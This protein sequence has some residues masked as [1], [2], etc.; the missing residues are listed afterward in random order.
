VVT[1]SVRDSIVM[2]GCSLVVLSELEADDADVADAPV[3]AFI[4]STSANGCAPTVAM[5]SRRWGHYQ[6]IEESVS[7][8]KW[9]SCSAGNNTKASV[10]RTGQLGAPLCDEAGIGGGGECAIVQMVAALA[11]AVWCIW[12]RC[13]PM[14]TKP[15]WRFRLVLMA[16]LMLTAPLKRLT[17]VSEY[18]QRGWRRGEC[19]CAAGHRWRNRWRT[20]AIGRVRGEL[21]FNGVQFAYAAD[22]RPA[23]RG[24]QLEYSCRRKCRAG[25]RVRQ[26]QDTL[27]NLVPRFYTPT[28]GAILLDGHNLEN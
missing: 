25:R 28:G 18:L 27:A 9:S 6:V 11:L 7:A 5:R 17:G 8:H 21:Q 3:I 13:N 2:V 4:I 16:M 10:Q 23:L 19:I 15:R 26:R 12:R 24:I 22:A 20:V 14:Q 1:I